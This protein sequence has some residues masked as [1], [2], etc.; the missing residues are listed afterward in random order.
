MSLEKLA[1]AQ[2]GV[3]RIG[4][5]MNGADRMIHEIGSFW[6]TMLGKFRSGPNVTENADRRLVWEAEHEEKMAAYRS[7]ETYISST[8]MGRSPTSTSVYDD[9]EDGD[10]DQIHAAVI[11]MRKKAVLMGEAIEEH[12]HRLDHLASETDHATGRIRSAR[13]NI[14]AIIKKS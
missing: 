8:T 12:N 1:K 2:D 4:D 13:Q 5:R 14:N 10:L 3:A 7:S 11:E 6:A 9:D